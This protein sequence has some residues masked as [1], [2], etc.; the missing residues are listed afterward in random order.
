MFATRATHARTA[1]LGF[2]AAA[3][4]ATAIAAPTAT[5]VPAPIHIS[6]TGGDG[7]LIRP[8]PSTSQPGVGWM[9]EGASPDYN[10]FTYGDVVGGVPVWFSVNYNG[11]TGYYA[12]FFDDS[13]YQSESD[14]TA[15]Y[16]VPK[17]G[18]GAPPAPA[19]PPTL[20][21]APDPT[22]T[23]GVPI[24]AVQFDR[25]ATRAWA[26]AHAKD[27]PPNGTS[28]TWFISQALWA[29]GLPQS[30]LW[31][32]AS[33]TFRSVPGTATAW[34]TPAFVQYVRLHLPRS[35]YQEISLRDN[36]VPA[37]QVGDVIVYD[38]DGKATTGNVSGLDHAALVTGVA[39]GQYPLVSEWSADGTNALRYSQRGW[40]WSQVH[41]TWLQSEPGAR[42]TKAFLLHIDPSVS[43][44]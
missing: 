21:P 20:T 24:P 41:G 31:S 34:Q 1:L 37:A 29:G 38:W 3:L 2:T 25:D 16:G 7:V 8:T 39:S 11:K 33:G 44:S 15:R 27:R 12:S 32:S 5:A 4:C 40:T 13:H 43:I 6:G 23:P 14:L 10:C 26:L 35:T 28:C 36:K 9:P 42:N 30:G 18:A 19:P 22:P 17:C